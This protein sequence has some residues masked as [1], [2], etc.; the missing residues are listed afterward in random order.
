MV[1]V[2]LLKACKEDTVCGSRTPLSLSAAGLENTL[3]RALDIMVNTYTREFGAFHISFDIWNQILALVINIHH[4]LVQLVKEQLEVK[5]VTHVMKGMVTISFN[6]SAYMSVI[7][8]PIGQ[9]M[10]ADNEVEVPDT[11]DVYLQ[12]VFATYSFYGK[13]NPRFET[14]MLQ[15]G[16]K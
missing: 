5:D 8:T 7:R 13:E 2:P 1:S 6:R 15:P 3:D 14:V 9:H 4:T 10:T 16:T 11:K 12:R